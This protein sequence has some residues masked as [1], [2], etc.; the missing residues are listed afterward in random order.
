MICSVDR[1]NAELEKENKD[2]KEINKG[3]KQKIEEL[4]ADK[5]SE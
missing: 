1:K 2:L 5:E 3:L 4:L